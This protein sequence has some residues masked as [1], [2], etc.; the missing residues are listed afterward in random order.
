MA[1]TLRIWQVA[2][3]ISIRVLIQY[4]SRK[5]AY[6]EVFTFLQKHAAGQQVRM[7]EQHTASRASLKTYSNIICQSLLALDNLSRPIGNLSSAVIT[8]WWMDS[9][10]PTP[11]I[12]RQLQRGGVPSRTLAADWSGF[13]HRRRRAA[14]LGWVRNQCFSHQSSAVGADWFGDHRSRDLHD[15]CDRCVFR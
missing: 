10:A 9:A 7:L 5:C 3:R 8:Q 13:D 11:P 14:G 1:I 4:K 12:G 2:L 15:T 6:R